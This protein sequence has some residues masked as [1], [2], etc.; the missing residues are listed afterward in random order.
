[1]KTTFQDIVQQPQ[2]I[3]QMSKKD[4]Q[5]FVREY[6]HKFDLMITENIRLKLEN[7]ELQNEINSYAIKLRGRK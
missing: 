3:S 4:A 6:M 5:R 2:L 1:M 7:D